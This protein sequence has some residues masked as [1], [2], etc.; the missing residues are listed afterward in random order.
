MVSSAKVH[1]IPGSLDVM[2]PK[3]KT[4]YLAICLYIFIIAVEW[5]HAEV[6]PYNLYLLFK[7]ENWKC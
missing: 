7:V 4:I 6:A 1:I 5:R 3:Y 2:V